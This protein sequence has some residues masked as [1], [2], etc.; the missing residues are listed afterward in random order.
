VTGAA[1]D[2]AMRTEGSAEAERIGAMGLAEAAGIKELTSVY[3]TLPD[4]AP[5]H[6]TGWD[7]D[8]PG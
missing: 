3:E 5:Q 6:H 1:K 7:A 8:Q 2:E 4:R